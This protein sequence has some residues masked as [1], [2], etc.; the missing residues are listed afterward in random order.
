MAG[1]PTAYRAEYCEQA[2]KLTQLGA[3]DR[4]LADFFKVVISTIS[5]WKT[6]HQ[7]FSD[8]LKLGKEEA[9]RRVEHSLYH[10]AM[11]YSHEAVKIFC[12]KEGNVTQVPY[13]EHYPPDTTACIFWL[14]NRK[15]QL[16]RDVHK[17]EHSGKVTLEDLILGK[18][19]EDH[20]AIPAGSRT[21]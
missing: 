12:D 8:A 5:L 17:V 6:E 3:T 15:Q 18:Q 16:W 20:D 9:D 7:A 1:R 11:G 19:P 4:E 13:T 14:K 2:K 21:N 10:R